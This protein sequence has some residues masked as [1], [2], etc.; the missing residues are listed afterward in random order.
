MCSSKKI[1]EET[2]TRSYESA[3][4]DLNTLQSNA[5]TLKQLRDA[6]AALNLLNLPETRSFWEKMGY[7]TSD[8]NRL[9]VIHVAGTKGKGSTC[10]FIDSIFQNTDFVNSNGTR[11]K[12][13][14]GLYTSPHLIEV[15]ERIRINGKPIEKDLFQRYFYE[16][17]DLLKRPHPPLNKVMEDS[18][19]MPMYFK[20][21]TLMAFH[22]FIREEVDV[23]I[24]EVGLGGEYDSTNMVEEPIV[25]GITSL[26]LDHQANLGNTVE[27]IAVHKAGISKKNV[28]LYSVPQPGDAGKAIANVCN[29]RETP[30]TFVNPLDQNVVTNSGLKFELGGKHHLSNAALAIQL[31]KTWFES[32]KTPLSPENGVDTETNPGSIPKWAIKGLSKA[33]WPGRSHVIE[34]STGSNIRWFIDGA[35]TVESIVACGEW[36][37]SANSNKQNKGAPTVV[38]F[39][40]AHGRSANIMFESLISDVQKTTDDIKIVLCPNISARA[41]SKNFTVFYDE[42]LELQHSLAKNISEKAAISEN[43]IHIFPTINDA[44]DY[45]RKEENGSNPENPTNVIVAG[46]LHLV[47]GVLDALGTSA[48]NFTTCATDN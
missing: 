20:Y 36:F 38:L 41:D 28:P 6:G 15:R 22:T 24:L 25:C 4:K 3:V 11:M 13:K 12:P 40:P 7:K 37:V 29:Q 43:D 18:P 5:A 45:I 44:V 33:K 30:L 17:W 42:K 27:E 16:T 48:S 47:G 35:H 32:E 26:G 1:V 34:P 9:N 8:L 23:A 2:S 21:L 39:N 19:D 10:A 14:V 31:C 46:S